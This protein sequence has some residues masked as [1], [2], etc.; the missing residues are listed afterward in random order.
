MA[1]RFGKYVDTGTNETSSRKAVTIVPADNAA[2]VDIPRR[3]YVGGAGDVNV[4]LANDTANVV[5]KAV[6]V[7]SYLNIAPK[8]IHQTGTSAT[9]IVA[10]Y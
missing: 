10:M 4:I 7:G 8:T 2:L 5:F 1:D 6:P 9:N 3:L